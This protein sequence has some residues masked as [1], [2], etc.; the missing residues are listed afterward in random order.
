MSVLLSKVV[1]PIAYS[2]IAFSASVVAGTHRL[3][4]KVFVGRVFFAIMYVAN[5][6]PI[7]RII[8]DFMMPSPS[9]DGVFVAKDIIIAMTIIPVA[10]II[11]RSFFQRFLMIFFD[12]FFLR[13]ANIVVKM[14]MSSAFVF[15]SPIEK[16]TRYSGVHASVIS[17][18]VFIIISP[19]LKL[20]FVLF[21]FVFAVSVFL[22]LVSFVVIVLRPRINSSAG[23]TLTE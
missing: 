14:R 13:L 22:S 4:K 20:F 21:S 10:V 7:G 23:N 11:E 17:G 3:L 9:V 2:I 18:R 1:V 16:R 19:S 15:I 12:P 6:K 5:P 8:H